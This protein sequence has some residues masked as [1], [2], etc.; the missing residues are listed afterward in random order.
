MDGTGTPDLTFSDKL[1]GYQIDFDGNYIIIDT[2]ANGITVDE[3]K[4][5]INLYADNADYIDIALGNNLSGSSLVPNGTKLLATAGNE[6]TDEVDTVEYTVIVLG[7]INCNGTVEVGDAVLITRHLVYDQELSTV[8]KLAA[9]TSNNGRID[10]GDA[11]RITRK[12]LYWD[13]Y[14]SLLEEVED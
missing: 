8:Q 14:K 3:L 4:A 10:V 12:K 1:A 6:F 2:H 5:L 13:E 7:D 11:V 9:D